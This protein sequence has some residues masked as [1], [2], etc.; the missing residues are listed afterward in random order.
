MTKPMCS[1]EQRKEN[2]EPAQGEVWL[3][4]EGPDS[5]EFRGSLIDCSKS[6]FRASHSNTSLSTGQ[7]VHFRHSV[8]KGSALVMWNRVLAEHVESGFL[9]LIK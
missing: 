4:V 2:R 1:V 8:G 7:H 9:I 6:G 3:A 5:R